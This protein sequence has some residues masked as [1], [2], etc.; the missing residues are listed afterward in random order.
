MQEE[1]TQSEWGHITQ[2]MDEPSF[3]IYFV[4]QD[5]DPSGSGIET[6]RL[7]KILQIMLGIRPQD[8]VSGGPSTLIVLFSSWRNSRFVLFCCAGHQ[9]I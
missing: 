9:S 4:V 7:Q 6:A 2:F 8:R 1:E 3:Y 5:T